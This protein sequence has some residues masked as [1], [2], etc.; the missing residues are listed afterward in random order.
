M[1]AAEFGET[2]CACTHLTQFSIAAVFAN[3]DQTNVDDLMPRFEALTAED[4]SNLTWEN[5]ARNPVTISTVFVFLCG[6]LL[7][8]PVSPPSTSTQ[9]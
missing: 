9:F 2:S 7:L 1:V 4:L 5:I 3:L 8:L 6:Y